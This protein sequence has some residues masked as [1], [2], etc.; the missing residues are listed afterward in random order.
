MLQKSIES[1]AM[2]IWGAAYRYL[3]YSAKEDTDNL[4]H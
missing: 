2:D 4:Q 1:D 3:R